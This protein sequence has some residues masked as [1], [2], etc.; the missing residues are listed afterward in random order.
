MLNTISSSLGSISK[1]L[2]F[3]SIAVLMSV[4][5]AANEHL[6]STIESKSINPSVD[7]PKIFFSV[8]TNKPHELTFKPVI[9][10]NF[11]FAFSSLSMIQTIFFNFDFPTRHN[12][13]FIVFAVSVVSFTFIILPK[14]LAVNLLFLSLSHSSLLRCPIVKIGIGIG[15]DAT[16]H[17]VNSFKKSYCIF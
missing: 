6:I 15:I 5:R 2:I 8:S 3:F 7:A 17:K 11:C 1:Y 10:S 16:S 9:S 4:F 12:I 13:S 14:L